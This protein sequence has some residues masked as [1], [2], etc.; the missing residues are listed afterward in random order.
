MSDVPP[1]NLELERGLIAMVLLDRDVLPKVDGWLPCEAFYSESHRLVYEAARALR[2][3][4]EPVDVQSAFQWLKLQG[5]HQGIGGVAAL[6]EMISGEAVRTNV[7]HYATQIF[8][9]WRLRQTI[10]A[11]HEATAKAYHGPGDVQEFLDGIARE[12]MRLASTGPRSVRETNLAAIQ[13]IVK[14]L[15]LARQR[16]DAGKPL[17]IPYGIPLL[18]ELTA[19]MHSGQKVTVVGLPGHGKTT[20]GIQVALS[21][22]RNGIGAL[23]FATEQQRDELMTKAICHLGRVDAQALRHSRL[24]AGGMRDFDA[25]CRELRDLPFT[26]EASPNFTV[27]DVRAKAF[28]VLEESRLSKFPLGVIIVDYV[29][30]LEPVADARKAE[31]H[32][33]VSKS[34]KAL[35]QLAQELRIPVVELVQR[36]S[37][38]VDPKTR[39]RPTPALGD[40][41]DSRDIDKEADVVLH[42]TRRPVKGADGK[43]VGES[44]TDYRLVLV[45]QR[46]GPE[47]QGINVTFDGATGRFSQAKEQDDH[48]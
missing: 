23:Y 20:F 9:L 34:T 3:K 30:R 13:R 22:A 16:A 45:K 27:A 41:A 42:I 37:C 29:Q 43:T 15:Q 14:T 5:K 18:D 2:A 11:M 25:A 12:A 40:C 1:S 35:K 31:K 10:A 4:G 24:D 28:S 32:V 33:Q 46:N 19:G 39:V 7:M 38:E 8:D 21:A 6:A 48:A 36:R 17:G 26:V 44:S 47:W